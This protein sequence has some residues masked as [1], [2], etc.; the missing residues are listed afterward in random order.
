LLKLFKNIFLYLAASIVM[1]HNIM[2]HQHHTE[3]SM[4]EDLREHNSTTLTDWLRTIFHEDLGDAHHL[5]NII[6]SSHDLDYDTASW[7]DD[8]FSPQP[9]FTFDFIPSFTLCYPYQTNLNSKP[10]KQRIRH[11]YLF[12]YYNTYLL[13]AAALRAPPSFI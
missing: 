10:Q 4:T 9:C 12:S 6:V 2:P 1:L 8:D 7:L 5:E 13:G 11:S 3:M